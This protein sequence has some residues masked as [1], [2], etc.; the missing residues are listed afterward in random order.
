M[1]STQQHN[2]SSSSQKAQPSTTQAVTSSSE[3]NNATATASVDGLLCNDQSG[4]CLVSKGTMKDGKDSG[5][6]TSLSR[7]AS[8][9]SF[10]NQEQTTNMNSTE[11]PL[12]TVETDK[13]KILIK[14]YE[15]HAVA[16]KVPNINES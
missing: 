4:L 3:A 2:S 16:M 11:S 10:P 9:L 8:Q 12:I 6:Y 14:E 13:N 1:A 5:A 7:L 15:G